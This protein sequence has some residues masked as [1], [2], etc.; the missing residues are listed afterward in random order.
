[1][2]PMRF[3]RPPR[4]RPEGWKPYGGQILNAVKVECNEG[5][6]QFCDSK[7]CRLRGLRRAVYSQISRLGFF[8]SCYIDYVQGKIVYLEVL[9]AILC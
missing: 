9:V 4:E 5:V 8:A 1:M 6:F 7:A 3:P 2:E